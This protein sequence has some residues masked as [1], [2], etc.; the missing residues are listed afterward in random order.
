MA[1]T[2]HNALGRAP[3][4]DDQ[5]VFAQA[6]QVLGICDHSAAS[7]NDRMLHVLKLRHHFTLI[8]AKTRFAIGSENI[9]DAF[10]GHAFDHFIRIDESEI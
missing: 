5:G 2:F 8:L 3:Q 6:G 10:V 7:G 4:A 9:T 1:D